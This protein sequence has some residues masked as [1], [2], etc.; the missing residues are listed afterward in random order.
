MPVPAAAK[1]GKPKIR[2][3]A[4][5]RGL[6]NGTNGTPEVLR[7]KRKWISRDLCREARFT[8]M[9]CTNLDSSKPKNWCGPKC[10]TPC[11]QYLHCV[12]YTFHIARL[13]VVDVFA[14]GLDI[15]P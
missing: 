1:A 12:G 11:S 13:F 8:L 7:L 5:R 9:R 3:G 14:S 2:I 10:P 4:S 15:I 6:A